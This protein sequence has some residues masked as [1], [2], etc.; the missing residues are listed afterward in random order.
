MH[1]RAR[2]S[3]HSV[4]FVFV[5]TRMPRA[6]AEPLQLQL[7]DVAETLD[8]PLEVVERQERE[9]TVRRAVL[10]ELDR[11]HLAAQVALADRLDLHEARERRHGSRARGEWGVE[12]RHRREGHTNGTRKRKAP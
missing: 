11:A 8:Q 1:W 2:R 9:R 4:R 6:L 10:A 5:E 12:R 7:V 3:D